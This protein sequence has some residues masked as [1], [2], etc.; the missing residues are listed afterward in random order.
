MSMTAGGDC[1]ACTACTVSALLLVGLFA[2]VTAAVAAAVAAAAA[3]AAAAAVCLLYTDCSQSAWVLNV[4]QLLLLCVVA[5]VLLLLLLL[6][7]LL[8]TGT[9]LAFTPKSKVNLLRIV[10][11][12]VLV[13][14]VAAEGLLGLL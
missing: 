11:T 10:V 3:A 2:S 12:A 4:L 14:L 9:A 6:L 5:S 7:R 8:L 13:G 1:A